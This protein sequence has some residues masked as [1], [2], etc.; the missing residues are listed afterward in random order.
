MKKLVRL[1]CLGL[2]IG[3]STSAQDDPFDVPLTTSTAAGD[4]P[5]ESNA[6]DPS[7]IPVDGGLSLLLSAGAVYGA[8]RLRKK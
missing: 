7:D 6:P 3:L 4:D 5:K 1:L 2:L 8:G